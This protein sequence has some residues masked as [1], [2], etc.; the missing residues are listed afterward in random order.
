M[1]LTCPTCGV[2]HVPLSP[3][4]EVRDPDDEIVGH[5]FIHIERMS[6]DM[7]CV[8]L[9]GPDGS[10]VEVTFAPACGG[11]LEM[12]VEEARK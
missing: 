7:V 6:P 5:G 4:I 2:Q 3:D 11:D 12:H 9:T 8:G 10:A 1:T